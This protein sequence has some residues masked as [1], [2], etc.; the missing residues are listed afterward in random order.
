ML[1]RLLTSNDLLSDGE[2][3]ESPTKRAS[4]ST[5]MRRLATIARSIDIKV[6]HRK[7]GESSSRTGD[8][9]LENSS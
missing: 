6:V 7:R 3:K 5:S 9:S 8:M 4:R 1:K 2:E